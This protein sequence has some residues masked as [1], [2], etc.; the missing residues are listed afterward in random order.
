[1]LYSLDVPSEKLLM[2]SFEGD[3]ATYFSVTL[4]S[5][6]R[7]MRCTMMSDLKTIVHVESRRRFCRARKISATPAS[8]VWVATR[9]CSTYL[10]LGGASCLYRL[11]QEF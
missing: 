5:P 1:M 6:S 3:S 7:I 9:M 8:P 2:A 4:G 10:A 11:G